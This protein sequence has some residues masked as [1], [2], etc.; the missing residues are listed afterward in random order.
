MFNASLEAPKKGG[1][2]IVVT[3]VRALPFLRLP[4]RFGDNRDFP[5]YT[6]KSNVCVIATEAD[7][8]LLEHVR[9]LNESLI[10][11]VRIFMEKISNWA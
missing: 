3:P 7:D 6:E 1:D 8:A 10:P 11:K 9:A 5:L 4:A 2:T